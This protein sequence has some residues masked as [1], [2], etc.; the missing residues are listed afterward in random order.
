[1][2]APDDFPPRPMGRFASRSKIAG[3]RHP[4]LRSGLPLR[5]R[6]RSGPPAAFVAMKAAMG[7][8]SSRRKTTMTYEHD[9]T[10][11]PHHAASPTDHVLQEL[12]L[13][14]YRP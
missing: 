2:A 5:V 10:Y 8:A 11:E 12:A 7:A 1:M 6:C 9:T 13:Y 4:P 3:L 14:G